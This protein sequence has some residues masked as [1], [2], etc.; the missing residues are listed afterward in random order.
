MTPLQL[1][2]Y[3]ITSAL[4][5]LH[6][7][8]SIYITSLQLYLYYITSALCIWHYCMVVLSKGLTYR[9]TL[10]VGTIYIYIRIISRCQVFCLLNDS[11]IV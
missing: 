4:F 3:D 1:Y 10:I 5:I 7:F 11:I 6:H 8:S 9:V 2:L